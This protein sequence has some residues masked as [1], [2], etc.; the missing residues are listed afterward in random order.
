VSDKSVLRKF[1][2]N[3]PQGEIPNRTQSPSS[4][5]ELQV[6]G[7]FLINAKKRNNNKLNGDKMWKIT[8]EEQHGSRRRKNNEG[9]HGT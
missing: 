2:N 3:L 7:K 1:G 9:E 6:N 4:S 5:V 8:M